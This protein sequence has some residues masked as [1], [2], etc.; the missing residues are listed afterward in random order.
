[1]SCKHRVT[2]IMVRLTPPM[3]MQVPVVDEALRLDIPALV[4]DRS[5]HACLVI[6]P[7]DKPPV[8]VSA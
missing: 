5:G 6:L 1:M 2:A 3:H 4:E 8:R 7:S